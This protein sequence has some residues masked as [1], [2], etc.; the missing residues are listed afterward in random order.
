MK[1]RENKGERQTETQRERGR[2]KEIDGETESKD[3]GTTRQALVLMQDM[4]LKRRRAPRS[5][6][7][8]IL[9][10]SSIVVLQ[11]TSRLLVRNGA[12][13]L[14]VEQGLSHDETPP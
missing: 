4:S 5:D 12:P 9:C 8:H 7:G 1:E 13:T 10:L 14:Q 2:G 6:T 3:E 11:T